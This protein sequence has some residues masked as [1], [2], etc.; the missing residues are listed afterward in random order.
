MQPAA[1]LGSM[2]STTSVLRPSTSPFGSAARF[3]LR[4]MPTGLN[5][6]P[7]TGL[8]TLLRPRSAPQLWCWNINQLPIGF[9]FRLHLRGRLTLPG[10][11]LDR[12][13]WVFGERVFHPLYRYSRQHSHFHT[14]QGRSRFPFAAYGTLPYPVPKHCYGFGIV[15]SPAIFTAQDNL[16]SELLRFL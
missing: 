15:L 14:L 5:L 6:N 2:G 16:T 12:N 9:A 11:S 7:I 10:L 4:S 1:F 13:P 8:L 3:I